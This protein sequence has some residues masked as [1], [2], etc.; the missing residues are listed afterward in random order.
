MR[1]Y[2]KHL[3]KIFLVILINQLFAFRNNIVAQENKIEIEDLKAT[4]SPAFTILGINPTAIERP[5]TPK[6]MGVTLLNAFN[7]IN[8]IPKSFAFEVTP[9]WLSSH[10]NLEFEDYFNHQS[11]VQNLAFSV[12]TSP[13]D[14]PSVGTSLSFGFRTML[15]AGAPNSDLK[16]C[17]ENYIRNLGKDNTRESILDQ[18][19]EDLKH[20][21]LVIDSSYDKSARNPND[22]ILKIDSVYRS[23]ILLEIKEVIKYR[24]KKD[25]ANNEVLSKLNSSER[26]KFFDDYRNF[27][28]KIVNETK[29]KDSDTLS[30][31]RKDE[32]YTIL[33][34]ATDTI[35]KSQDNIFIDSLRNVN[36][37]R[38]GWKL[39]TSFAISG[40]FKNDSTSN[41]EWSKLGLWVTP[42]YTLEGN[43]D[44]I[45]VLRYFGN[46]EANKITNGEYYAGA[47]VLYKNGDFGVSFETLSKM[48]NKGKPSFR[49][50]LNLDYKLYDNVY[51]TGTFGKNFDGSNIE[52]N[53][54]L[55]TLLGINFGMGKNPVVSLKK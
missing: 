43:I 41:G 30:N 2:S 5:Q 1:N 22:S 54:N 18:I 25:S 8:V 47:R 42:A 26:P 31:T 3:L 24:I 15:F 14:S 40:D 50:A 32:L 13:L 49:Y 28:L 4:G 29:F 39:E 27:L 53:G 34:T 48:Q 21:A 51:I 35:S 19:N 23:L 6:A 36:K 46:F 12:A 7:N 11:A 38:V 33:N 16:K 10:N 44:L 45:G 52:G 55:I 9:Y 17:K 37:Y 20:K